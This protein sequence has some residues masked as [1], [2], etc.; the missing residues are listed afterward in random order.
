MEEKGFIKKEIATRLEFLN[1][2]VEE[3]Q[4]NVENYTHS[5]KECKELI[6]LHN[7]EIKYLKSLDI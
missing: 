2:E 3:H 1:E 7:K 6:R 4:A 5:I